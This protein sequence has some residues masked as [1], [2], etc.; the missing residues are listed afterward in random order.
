MTDPAADLPLTGQGALV[1]GGGSG[2]GLAVARQL[3]AAGVVVTICGRTE[4]RLTEAVAQ[5][6]TDLPD[7]SVHAAVADVTDEDA[8]AAAVRAADDRARRACGAVVASAGGSES[9]G[10][11]T[12]LDRR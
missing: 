7:A 10:P 2:I 11:V 4:A 5:L 3:A 6:S 1:T 9:I 8:V 12:H